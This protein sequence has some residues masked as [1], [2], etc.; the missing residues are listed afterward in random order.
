MLVVGA[1]RPADARD[2][3]LAAGAAPALPAPAAHSARHRAACA[4]TRS[5][6][7]T[8]ALHSQSLHSQ[9]N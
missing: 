8:H 5:P 7:H 4:R 2:P 1:P 6:A 3:P 9:T